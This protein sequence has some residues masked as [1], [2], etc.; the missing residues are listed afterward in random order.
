VPTP[1]EIYIKDAA[2]QQNRTLETTDLAAA[3]GGAADAAT[4][5]TLTGGTTKAQVS[6]GTIQAAVL[7]TDPGAAEN[8][9]VVRNQPGLTVTYVSGK[10]ADGTP[11]TQ[12]PVPVGGV[13]GSGNAQTLATDTAGNVGVVPPASSRT[14][15][16]MSAAQATDAV[17]NGLTALTPAFAKI[18]RA[19]NADGAAL[20]NLTAS[21]K[22]RVL[23]Y[24]LVCA[25]AS[26]VKWQSSTSNVNA[27]GSNTDLTPVMS[28]AANGGAS[29][30]YCPLGHFETVAGEALKLNSNSTNQV[31]GH[32]VYVVV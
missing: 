15:D 16:S 27:T 30:A 10:D 13:D 5:T 24:T 32:L 2:T 28:F 23:A 7:A 11:L 4:N 19:T 26:G 17:M 31:S 21:K 12:K 29:V 6:N 14:V 25:G 20:V 3:G 9:L 18:D 8:G 22:I 1:V